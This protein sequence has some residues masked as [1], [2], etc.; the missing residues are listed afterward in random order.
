VKWFLVIKFENFLGKNID[1]CLMG[2]RKK[3]K[4][5]FGKNKCV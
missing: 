4:E 5:P 3:Y 2:E 1:S